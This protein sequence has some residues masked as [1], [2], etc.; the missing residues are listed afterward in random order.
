MSPRDRWIAITVSL[1]G[2]GVCLAAML[3]FLVSIRDNNLP[4]SST[5]DA[6]GHYLAVGQS[7]SEGFATGFFLCFFLALVVAAIGPWIRA[8]RQASVNRNL[9]D[10]VNSLTPVPVVARRPAR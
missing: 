8:R 9:A 5:M 4:W 1:A 6:R 7:Y 10:S 3:L 2:I